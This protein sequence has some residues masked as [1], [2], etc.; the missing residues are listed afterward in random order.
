MSW[1]ISSVKDLEDIIEFLKIDEWKN[2]QA[3]SEY[4]KENRVLFPDTKHTLALIYRDETKRV[5]GIIILTSRGLIYPSLKGY[6]YKDLGLKRELIKLFSTIKF[7][8]HG[9]VGIRDD[10][11]YLDSII[12]NRLRGWFNY[13]LLYRASTKKFTTSDNYSIK[14]ANLRDLDRII[15]LE[16]EYQKEEVLLNPG[17]LNKKATYNHLKNKLTDSEIYYLEI[18]GSP[19][20]KGGT[21]SKSSKYTLLGGVFTV[22]ELRNMGYS[23]SLLKYIINDQ[24]DKGWMSALFVKDNNIPAL[25]VYTNLGFARATPYRINY[26]YK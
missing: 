3:L 4:I 26:Y 7:T 16:Y 9:V 25:K 10:V 14:E 12:F 19:V 1:Y 6:D 13:T 5:L 21:T 15:D 8:M 18:A 24:L 2:I 20:S 11:N 23:T 22:R 17:D